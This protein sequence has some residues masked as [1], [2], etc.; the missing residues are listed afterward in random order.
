MTR[1]YFL[2]IRKMK[3]GAFG[4]ILSVVFIS[5]TWQLAPHKNKFRG[6]DHFRI[7][8]SPHPHS[9]PMMRMFLTLYMPKLLGILLPNQRRRRYCCFWVPYSL[10]KLSMNFSCIESSFPIWLPCLLTGRIESLKPLSLQE[11]C[12]SLSQAGGQEATWWPFPHHPPQVAL[13]PFPL[14]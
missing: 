5:N 12:W 7:F 8:P 6:E 13:W 11:G 9:Y 2:N 1:G 4:K 3:G 10:R 14:P